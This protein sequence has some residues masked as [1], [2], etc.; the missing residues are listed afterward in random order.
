MRIAIFGLIGPLCLLAGEGVA[1]ETWDYDVDAVDG[2][3][4]QVTEDE[5]TLGGFCAGETLYFFA[6]FPREGLPKSDASTV[7]F[8][9]AKDTPPD[10]SIFDVSVIT[11]E[12]QL[13]DGRAA[14]W[15]QGQVAVDWLEDMRTARNNVFIA[16]ETAEETPRAVFARQ[17]SVRGSTA[18]INALMAECTG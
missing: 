2:P 17:F 11:R 4:A 15:F 9:F 13:I 14:V 3:T 5:Y 7:R 1:Q 8:K 6:D 16:V 12:W 10:D 18:A